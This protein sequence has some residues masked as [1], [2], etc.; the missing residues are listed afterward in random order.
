MTA[1]E[2]SD[3]ELSYEMFWAGYLKHL[4]EIGAVTAETPADEIW[5]MKAEF[6]AGIRGE[7][8]DCYTSEGENE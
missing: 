1:P 5:K 6:M 8:Q 2:L 7:R 4:A 3:L